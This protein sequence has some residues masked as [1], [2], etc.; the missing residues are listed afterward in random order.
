MVSSSAYS[1]ELTA[2][3]Y[4]VILTIKMSSVV[5]TMMPNPHRSGLGNLATKI[6]AQDFVFFVFVSFSSCRRR[7]L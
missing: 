7:H 1:I 3:I 6:M 4:V 5:M 2:G